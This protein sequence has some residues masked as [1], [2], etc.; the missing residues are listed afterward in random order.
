VGESGSGKSTTGLILLRLIRFQG[1]VLLG[2]KDM[3][4]LNS[5]QLR[6]IRANLQIVFQDPYGSLAP[7]LTVGDIVAEGLTVH[8]KQLSRAEREDKVAAIL[9]EVAA[10]RSPICSSATTSPPSARSRTG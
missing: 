4:T 9:Q 7:R 10:T 1:K 2:G 6:G 8:A 5:K 3:G